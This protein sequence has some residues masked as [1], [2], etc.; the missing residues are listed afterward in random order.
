LFSSK[1]LE[2]LHKNLAGVI[3]PIAKTF[4]RKYSQSAGSLAELCQKLAGEITNDAQRQSFLK[5]CQTDLGGES[6]GHL[7]TDAP[8]ITTPVPPG[9]QTMTWDPAL[10]ERAKTSLAAI[11]GP[12]AKVIV[13]RAAKRAR[14]LDELYSLITADLSPKDRDKFLSSRL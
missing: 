6:L 10:L 14:S 4:V 13:S 2:T 11:I 3:G 8:R 12:L 1:V 7:V 9:A 5:A